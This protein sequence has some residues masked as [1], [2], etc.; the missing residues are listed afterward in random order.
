MIYIYILYL[1]CIIYMIYIYIFIFI[2]YIYISIM[3]YI[4]YILYLLCIIYM[5]FIYILYLLCII[6]MRYIYY[7]YY[8]L[9]I[10][11][12]YILYIYYVLYIW[13]I[14]IYKPIHFWNLTSPFLRILAATCGSIFF[15]QGVTD[16]TVQGVPTWAYKDCSVVRLVNG[17]K[18]V[19]PTF[20]KLVS[21]TSELQANVHESVSGNGRWQ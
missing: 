20:H 11:Y 15:L 9:F 17:D 21:K 16:D 5:I 12:I 19:W 6:Y 14:Y 1:L 10:W 13:Y 18:C 8:V 4:I 3:Y 7:I 2:I